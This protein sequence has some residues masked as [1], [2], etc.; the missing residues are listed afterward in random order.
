[1]ILDVETMGVDNRTVKDLV[2][3]FPE[4]ILIALTAKPFN[5][6]LRESICRYFYACVH[7]P[8]DLDELWYLIRSS[9]EKPQ[10]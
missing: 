10:G 3:K 5:P 7:K 2:S 6:E 1:V 8:V 9:H 4:T